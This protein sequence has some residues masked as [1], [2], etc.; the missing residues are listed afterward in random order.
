MSRNLIL[1]IVLAVIGFAVWLYYK[2]KN[3]GLTFIPDVAYPHGTEAIPSNYNPN[4]LADEL[5]EVMKGLFTSPATKEKAFQKLYN[6][7]TDDLLVLVYNTFNKKYGREGSGSL[8]KWIDDEVIHTYGFFTSS[9][10][11]KLLARLR[12]INLK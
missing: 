5:H 2:G 7:P 4:P 10:K 9:I 3:A 12:S 1:V 11:S 8:T 6:L